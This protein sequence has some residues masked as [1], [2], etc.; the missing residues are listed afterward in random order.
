MI[1]TKI[2][3]QLWIETTCANPSRTSGGRHGFGLCG[4]G[5]YW[6][7]LLQACMSLR[8]MLGDRCLHGGHMLLLL[9]ILIHYVIRIGIL[10]SILCEHIFVRIK[11]AYPPSTV[12]MMH[13]RWSV[14]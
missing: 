11:I 6:R 3:N 10:L 13:R 12:R 2:F 14:L 4:D 1:R 9:M 8:F 5:C 7:M